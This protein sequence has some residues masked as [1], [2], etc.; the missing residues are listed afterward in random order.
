MSY[1]YRSDHLIL[2]GVGAGVLVGTP[3]TNLHKYIW[4]FHP[5]YNI[6]TE[7]HSAAKVVAMYSSK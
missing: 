6:V 4:V 3:Q 5:H 1:I 2:W 7:Y